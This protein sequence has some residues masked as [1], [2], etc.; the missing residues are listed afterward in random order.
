MSKA[1]TPIPADRVRAVRAF[2]RFY[3]RQIGVLQRGVLQSPYSLTEVR[4]LYEL[5]NGMDLTA[6]ELERLLDLDPGYLSR[7]LRVFE[8]R[9]MLLRER[10]RKDGRQRLLRL[11]ARGRKVFSELDVRQSREVGKMLEPISEDGHET[12][13]ASMQAIQGVLIGKSGGKGKVSV[14]THSPGDMGWVMFRHGVLYD[15][16]YGWDERFEALVGEI[17]VNFLKNFDEERERCWIAEID[18]KRVGSIFLVKESTTVA[19]LRLLLV[20][21]SARGHGVGKLLVRECIDFAQKAGYRKLTLWTN[22]VLDAARHLYE[23]AGFRLV[24]EEKHTSFG[25]ELT[26]QYW[27]LEL[28]TDNWTEL[29]TERNDN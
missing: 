11:T 7:I 9:G 20:E 22:S 8:R 12:L 27:E 23:V 19:K 14:R 10:S 1:A 2:N 15:R 6:T 29:T 13:I 4:V 28:Q 5:A 25:H 21:P 26:G 3:T 17:V 16:E 18:G 24:K